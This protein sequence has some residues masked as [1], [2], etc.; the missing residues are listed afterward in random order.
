MSRRFAQ[1]WDEKRGRN[2][3]YN[4]ETNETTWKKPAGL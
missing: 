4:V 2:Y 3:Y 1:A